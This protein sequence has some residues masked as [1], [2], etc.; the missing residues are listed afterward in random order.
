MKKQIYKFKGGEIKNEGDDIV[1]C[2]DKLPIKRVDEE[3]DLND[4]VIILQDFEIII[5]NTV[6]K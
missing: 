5:R 2:L 6:H 3:D 4:D 1:H